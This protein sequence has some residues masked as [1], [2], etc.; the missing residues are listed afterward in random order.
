MTT[1]MTGMSKIRD[2]QIQ[3]STNVDSGL[4]IQGKINLCNVVVGVH[5][6]GDDLVSSLPKQNTRE[7]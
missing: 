6:L 4:H 5:S 3:G 7:A 1:T 2:N